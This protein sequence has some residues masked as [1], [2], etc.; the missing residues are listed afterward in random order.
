MGSFNVNDKDFNR[1]IC[2]PNY[3][4]SLYSNK[5]MPT[6]SFGTINYIGNRCSRFLKALQHLNSF[7]TEKDPF[8]E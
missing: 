5:G 6:N 3:D 7:A 4:L 1:T 8:G 2:R